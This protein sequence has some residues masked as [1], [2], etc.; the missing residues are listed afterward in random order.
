MA[1]CFGNTEVCIVQGYVFTDEGNVE[2]VFR[3]INGID[4]FFPVFHVARFIGQVKLF[5]DN[6]VQS[7]VRKQERY[8]INA[9]EGFIFDNG[10]F[11]NI[12][13]QSQ[14]IFHFIRQGPFC[15]ANDDI[16]LNANTAQFFDTVLCRF[17]LQFAGSANV[18]YQCN[19]NVEHVVTAD[20]LLDLTDCFEERQAFDIAYSTANF[21]NDDIGIIVIPYAIYTFF[22]FIGNVGN[23]LDGVAQIIAAPFFLQYRPVNFTGR[24]VRVLAQVNVDKAFIM[25]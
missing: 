1:E 21:R 2:V 4:H 20:F 24:N 15:T 13:E 22:N 6:A 7:F 23:D 10:F 3:M 19:V 12:A 11:I 25:T 14:L 8:F 16:R 17:C 18:R 9:V 5:Q